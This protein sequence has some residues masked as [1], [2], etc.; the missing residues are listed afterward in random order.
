MSGISVEKLVKSLNGNVVLN[1]VS[2]EAAPGELFFVLG[3]G[4]SGK[5]TLLRVLAGLLT[6][7]SGEISID[8]EKVSE[9]AT[10]R[11]K[12]ALV[13]PDGALL[14]HSSV[15]ENLS[16]A[17]EQQGRD[18]VEIRGVV[19]AMLGAF[20]VGELGG[21]KPGE[22]SG[23]ERQRVALARALAVSPRVLLLD[24][25]FSWLDTD[26]RRNR[27]NAIRQICRAQ[28]LAALCVTQ[29]I[30]EALAVADQVGVLLDGRLQQVASPL[31]I[32]RRPRT[33]AVGE[34]L[35]GANVLPGRLLHAG[36]GEFVAETA[37]GE[38]RGALSD[39]A[40]EPAPGASVDV[41]IRPEVLHIDMVAP[42]ENAFEGVVVD[43]GAYGGASGRIVFRAKGGVELRVL[44]LNPR[45]ANPAAGDALFVWVAP[46]DV[47][48]I[49][50]G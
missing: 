6:P 8:G 2:L 33:R 15:R 46:E 30:E 40:S 37:L 41:L 4:G 23:G 14:A 21:R 3:P 43:G 25:P 12:V 5:S 16:F 7:D 29:H 26:T 9:L 35:S 10:I 19:H 44:E 36:A 24:E 20:G 27:W 50:N 49:V 45:T 11:R 28:G 38:V 34:F 17:L 39:P 1:G 47:T 42:D 22:L 13:S 18:E 31:E 32:Y 48:G